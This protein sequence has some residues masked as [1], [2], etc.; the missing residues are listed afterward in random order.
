[1]NFDELLK[2]QMIS[3]RQHDGNES[4]KHLMS[5]SQNTSFMSDSK[6]SRSALNKLLP[7]D[8]RH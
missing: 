8:K 3:L 7:D 6:P 5:K 2:N 4:E 1:M